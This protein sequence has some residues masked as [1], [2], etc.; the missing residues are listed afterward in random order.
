MGGSGDSTKLEDLTPGVRA[1]GVAVGQP[2]TVV[3]VR[4][5]GSNAVTVTYRDDA[6][7]LPPAVDRVGVAAGRVAA[8]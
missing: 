2:V 3:D 1:S 5:H 4:W 6:G 8:D 7:T